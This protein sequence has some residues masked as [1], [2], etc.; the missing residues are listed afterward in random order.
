MSNVIETDSPS[1]VASPYRLSAAEVVARLKSDAANGLSEAEAA[2]RHGEYGP[3]QLQ[4]K[5]PVP[6]WKKFLAQFKDPL[7]LLLIVITLSG[8]AL[9]LNNLWTLIF[10]IPAII[11]CHFVLIVPEERYLKNKFGGVYLEYTASLRRWFG[12]KRTNPY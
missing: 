12:R 9:G 11:L 4:A 1:A 6:G 3:N 8:I 7:V 2:R 5:P 10:L